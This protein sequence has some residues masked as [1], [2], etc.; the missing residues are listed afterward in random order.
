MDYSKPAF[1]DTWGTIHVALGA[2][3]VMNL[4]GNSIL[5][6]ENALQALLKAL[7]SLQ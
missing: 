2:C 3:E 5:L 6:A 4:L 1:F 7:F